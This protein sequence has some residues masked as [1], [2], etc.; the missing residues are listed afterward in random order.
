LAPGATIYLQ[1]RLGVQQAGTFRFFV[2][3]EALP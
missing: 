2:L 1:W 3:V